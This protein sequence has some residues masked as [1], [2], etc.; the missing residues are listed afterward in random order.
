MN[1]WFHLFDL[2]IQNNEFFKGVMLSIFTID[3]SGRGDRDLFRLEI[4]NH[5]IYLG[6]FFLTLINTG[7]CNE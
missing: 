5:G 6:L 3:T 1:I 2:T 4:S 7:G